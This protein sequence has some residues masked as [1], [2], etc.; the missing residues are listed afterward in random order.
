MWR[1]VG[2][3]SLFCLLV[4]FCITAPAAAQS[5]VAWTAEYFNNP[6]LSGLPVLRQVET[7]PA[8][9]WGA[10]SPSPALPADYF[11]VR[12]TSIQ[13]TPAAP[14]TYQLSVQADDGV[15]VSI[16]GILVI[17][18]WHL[19]TA[20]T[21]TTTLTLNPGAHTFIVEY[22]EA[23]GLAY[24]QYSFAALTGGTTTGSTAFITTPL[25]NVRDAPNPF[26]GAI[27]TR[28]RQGETY[29]VVGKNADSSW[30]Q[31][32]VN[33]VTGWVN[34]SYTAAANLQLVPVTDSG[35]RPTGITA[36]VTANFLN[37]RQTPDPI[38]GLIVARIALGQTYAVMGRNADSS[39]VQLNVNGVSGWV[40]RVYVYVPNVQNAP[41][42]GAGT[43]I[44]TA[45]VT[46]GMLNVRAV[47]D[48]IN[49]LILTRI[50]RGQTYPVIGRNAA[51]TWVQLSLTNLGLVGWV[52]A[53]YVS[54]TN[55]G[56]LPV[57]G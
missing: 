4:L 21:T 20:K 29:S 18:E 8:H 7:S 31:L 1:K 22:Y 40:N 24:L 14:V 3:W 56:S 44:G 43:A 25:L 53:K 46:T 26:T 23:A 47:P 11:S 49:G 51:G 45:T 33:G 42:V 13:T 48:P 36:T 57:T 55:L 19:A 28:V 41:V 52:N 39:W 10:G 6:N 38:N 37:V 16:D 5:G 9:D 30:I 2:F 12:W 32:N 50:S 54:V 15:R 34:A 27:L 35:T 17:N